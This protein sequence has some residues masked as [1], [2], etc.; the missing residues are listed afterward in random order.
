MNSKFLKIT[1]IE[2]ICF[3]AEDYWEHLNFPDKKMHF[4]ILF[5]SSCS[6]LHIAMLLYKHF[7][8][9]FIFV[10]NWFFIG[11][12]MQLEGTENSVYLDLLRLFAHGTWSDYKSK[13]T[14]FYI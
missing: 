6:L 10:V 5:A 8:I 2:S 3:N 9:S 14:F 13:R 11:T 7:G 4:D 1:G 12:C